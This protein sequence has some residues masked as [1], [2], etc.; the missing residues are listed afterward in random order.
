MIRAE[1]LI[2]NFRGWLGSFMRKSERTET[3]NEYQDIESLQDKADW[4]HITAWQKLGERNYGIPSMRQIKQFLSAEYKT[5]KIE[6]R[7]YQSSEGIEP[8]FEL[9]RRILEQAQNLKDSN[10]QEAAS[11][12]FQMIIDQLEPVCNDPKFEPQQ[13]ENFKAKLDLS[14]TS[15][16]I[17]E[18]TGFLE[19]S[20]REAL[21]PKL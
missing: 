16:R 20:A 4:Q 18:M 5:T 10:G 9:R 21:K 19:K 6:E 11:A 2:P 8:R 15:I 12:Y 1:K 17:I 7:I 13:Q 3:K 14:E